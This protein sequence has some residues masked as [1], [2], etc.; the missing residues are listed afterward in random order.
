MGT[1]NYEDLEFLATKSKE[2]VETQRNSWRQE[3][4]NAT[5][6]ITII[7]IFLPLYING[8]D[9]TPK[10]TRYLSVI[11]ISLF[12]IAVVLLL[13]YVFLSKTVY[14]G[15]NFERFQELIN[16]Q[17]YNEVLLYEI[18]ANKASFELNDA[19]LETRK[20]FYNRS[21]VITG[22]AILLSTALLFT[23][24]ITVDS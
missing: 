10:I 9:S 24:L 6:V 1:E 14:I 16:A 11:P 3:Q 17:K 21:V 19:K 4:N 15:T 23:K 18:G 22:I 5:A 12:L 2:M 20:R 8:L 7:A 13:R